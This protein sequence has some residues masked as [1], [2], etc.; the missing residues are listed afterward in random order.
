MATQSRD[1]KEIERRMLGALCMGPL[2]LD[3]RSEALRSLANY[4]WILPDHRVIYEVLRRSRQRNSAALRENIVAEITRLGFPDID[5]E[6]FF[7]PCSLT[8]AQIVGLVNALLPAG[9]TPA[10][11]K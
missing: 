4:D 7:N 11:Q 5:V 6:P 1:T 2:S 9:R 10:N 3:D 8:K